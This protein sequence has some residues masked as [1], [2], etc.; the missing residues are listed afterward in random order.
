MQTFST[1]L[2]VRAAGRLAIA[3]SALAGIAFSLTALWVGKAAFVAFL[4]NLIYFGAVYY[5]IR[6][7]NYFIALKYEML[8]DL[9]FVLFAAIYFTTS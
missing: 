5:R 8:L 6:S 4:A 3:V 7:K 2:G 1:M 9:N